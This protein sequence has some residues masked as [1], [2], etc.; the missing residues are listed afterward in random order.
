M[1]FKEMLLQAKAGREP[2]VIAILE[3]YKPLLI[4]YAIINGR[5]DEDLYQELCIILLKCIARFRM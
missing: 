4:K 2:A 5:F 3:M 1:N